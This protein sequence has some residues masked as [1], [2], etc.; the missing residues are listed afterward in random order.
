MFSWQTATLPD[1]PYAGLVSGLILIGLRMPLAL[2]LFALM[3][4]RL[5]ASLRWRDLFPGT[6]VGL[7]LWLGFVL[8]LWGLAYTTPAM[9]AFFTSLSSL[10]VPILFWMV[11]RSISLGVWAGYGLAFIG[12]VVL[13]EGGWR[14]GPG[15]FLSLGCSM[16]FSLQILALD[17]FGRGI[18]GN[19]ITP[20]LFGV[21]GVLSFLLVGVLC[22]FG[23]TFE[24]WQNWL[25]VRLSHGPT[26]WELAIMVVVPTLMSY[27]LMNAFQPK[28]S[29]E[30]AAIIYLL[31]P[32]F[33][34]LFSLWFGHDLLHTSL[35]IGG[36]LILAGVAWTELANSMGDTPKKE[37]RLQEPAQLD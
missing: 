12:L 1:V 28:L 18:D 31:E 17:R 7:P 34:L 14:W 27:S 35:V 29:A 8:Q 37:M 20:V 36:L 21:N 32:V 13:V 10:W 3:R 2:V 9:S 6:M 24:I 11:G 15:E 25:L 23:G 30:R 19:R 16:V 33:S 5:V 26:L 4:P 22:F